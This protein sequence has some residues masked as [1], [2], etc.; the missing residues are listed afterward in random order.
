MLSIVCWTSAFHIAGR[1]SSIISCFLFTQI[2]WAAIYGNILFSE[3]LDL[4]SIVGIIIII[5]AGIIAL[6]N[7]NKINIT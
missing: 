3:K 4:V 6:N 1:Y 5:F 7:N 2:I